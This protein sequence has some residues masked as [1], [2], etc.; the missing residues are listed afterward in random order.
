M[1]IIF[2]AVAFPI[3][4][5]GGPSWTQDIGFMHEVDL[6]NH[7][8]VHQI[9]DMEGWKAPSLGGNM[10]Q[11]SQVSN[12]VK[13]KGSSVTQ[14]LGSMQELNSHHLGVLQDQARDDEAGPSHDGTVNG[15][16]GLNWF[17]PTEVAPETISDDWFQQQCRSLAEV[18]FLCQAEPLQQ[19]A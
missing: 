14:A 7:G 19:L 8:G 13:S 15:E 17:K 2:N 12:W 10:E 5:P 16:Q 18:E 6:Q 3:Y 1:S 4:M 11:G 9:Q